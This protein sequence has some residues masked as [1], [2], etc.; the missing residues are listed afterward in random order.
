MKHI[1]ESELTKETKLHLV[2]WRLCGHIWKTRFP[3]DML[4]NQYSK[5]CPD[6]SVFPKKDW[7]PVLD[8]VP[9]LI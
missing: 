7:S 3:T 4:K 8:G 6:C 5:T 9:E 1:Q 2:R